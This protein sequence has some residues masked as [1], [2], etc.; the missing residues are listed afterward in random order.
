MV[1]NFLKSSYNKVKNALGKTLLGQK[2]RALFGGSINEET[3]EHLE[4]LLYEAD[5]GVA[6]AVELTEKVRQRLRVNSKL[7]GDELLQFLREDLLQN[8]RNLLH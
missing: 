8:R 4:K 7:T 3:L 6:L 5:L 1:L 2:I